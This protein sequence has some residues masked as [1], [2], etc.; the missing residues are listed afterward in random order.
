MRRQMLIFTPSA[1]LLVNCAVG[2]YAQ[3][4]PM[5]V[6]QL[7]QLLCAVQDA[8][9]HPQF[10]L[11]EVHGISIAL[12]EGYS[13]LVAVLCEPP[14][15]SIEVA[16]LLGMQVLNAFG[17]LFRKV[18]ETLSS[19]HLRQVTDAVSTYTFHNAA[20]GAGCIDAD[21]GA[22]T[23]C[24]FLTFEQLVMQPLLLNP[25][26]S[27][28]LKHCERVVT[29]LRV[30]L[31]QPTSLSDHASILLQANST[32]THPLCAFI[33]QHI[34]AVWKAVTRQVQSM[35]RTLSSAADC[36]TPSR[37]IAA[38][39]F[40]SLCDNRVC[41]H[42]AM[43]AVRLIPNGACC[44]IFYEASSLLSH[45]PGS[46]KNLSPGAALHAS[47]TF[48]ISVLHIPTDIRIALQAMATAV[49]AAFPTA[50][51]NLRD[52]M[53]VPEPMDREQS[54]QSAPTTPP[55]PDSNYQT[56]LGKA[57]GEDAKLCEERVNDMSPVHI[58]IQTPRD[59]KVASSQHGPASSTIPAGLSS[60]NED[61]SL[62]MA[63]GP[64]E[65]GR[66]VLRS[67]VVRGLWKDVGSAANMM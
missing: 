19:E 57:P 50:V 26:A 63:P 4:P 42:A 36:Q 53:P 13:I 12:L 40:P 21:G 1:K 38:I 44:T 18:V 29:I 11:L 23:L 16:R 49:E 39:A 27:S 47:S 64:S 45:Q 61:R 43:L 15:V 34:P 56:L 46:T 24:D 62:P 55:R 8:A 22:A 28:W 6:K 5:D 41:L 54:V 60:E 10:G 65:R 58:S 2:Q 14:D 25:P 48:S 31:L 9:A 52:V 7:C 3:Q 51:R 67:S 17:K 20:H 66:R 33:G 37:Q 30:L 59:D 32:A 35:I